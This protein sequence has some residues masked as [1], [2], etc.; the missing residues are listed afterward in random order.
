MTDEIDA[1]INK[2]IFGGPNQIEKDSAGLVVRNALRAAGY[3]IASI[4]EP[5]RLPTEADHRAMNSFYRRALDR[6]YEEGA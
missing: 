1:I 5:P 6:I 3:E 4:E 2:A